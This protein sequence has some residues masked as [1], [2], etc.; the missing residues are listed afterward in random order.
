MRLITFF[1]LLTFI[2]CSD[3]QHPKSIDSIIEE[4]NEFNKTRL[5][6]TKS[7]V[8]S[9]SRGYDRI[10]VTDYYVPSKGGVLLK[11][12]EECKAF[13][14][15]YSTWK[16]SLE[17]ESATIKGISRCLCEI[18]LTAIAVD[19]CGNTYFSVSQVEMYEY[20]IIED[21]NCLNDKLGYTP[22]R[23]KC[24]KVEW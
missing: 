15:D 6:G 23:G 3:G 20:V 7:S 9:R 11:L 2:A 24:Y 8:L 13:V 14:T 10:I 18:G 1:L 4:V 19:S 21:K 22:F 16:D 17:L 12:N 5:Y